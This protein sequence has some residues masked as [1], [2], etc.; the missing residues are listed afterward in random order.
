MG[1]LSNKLIVYILVFLA[2]FLWA[3]ISSFLASSYKNKLRKAEEDLTLYEE[4]ESLRYETY[5][6]YRKKTESIEKELDKYKELYH[7]AQEDPTGIA[8][9]D[10]EI[11]AV[12]DNSL[13]R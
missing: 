6:N 2:M 3:L 13:P 12:I 10:T 1:F 8:Y 11:P 5:M 4:S 7:E 9:L